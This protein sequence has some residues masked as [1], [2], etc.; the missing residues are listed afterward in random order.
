[1][2]LEAGAVSVK[3]TADVGG[4]KTGAKK[5]ESSLGQINRATAKTSKGLGVMQGALG[6]ML[7]ALG[8]VGLGVAAVAAVKSLFNVG[9]QMEKTRIAFQALFGSVQKGNKALTD[10]VEFANRTP[11]S[12]NNVVEATKLLKG[13]GIASDDISS[14]LT[15]VG[16]A[17]AITGNDLIALAN[18][19]GKSLSKPTVEQESL[20]QLN[21][22][23]VGIISALAKE[24]NTTTEG[25]YALQRAGK[26]TQ[27]RFKKAFKSMSD[28]G[29]VYFEGMQK[30]SKTFG[31]LFSTLLGKMQNSWAML[32]EGTVSSFTGILEGMIRVYDVL[33]QVMKDLWLVLSGVL[34]VSLAFGKAV[35]NAFIGFFSSFSR[36]FGLFQ[37]FNGE[38]QTMRIV[39]TAIGDAFKVLAVGVELLGTMFGMIGTVWGVAYRLIFDGVS[40]IIGIFINLLA[41][42]KPVADAFGWIAEKWKDFMS[43]L[44]SSDVGFLD[45]FRVSVAK[46][47]AEFTIVIETMVKK[48]REFALKAGYYGRIAMS[49]LAGGEEAR[50]QAKSQY[51]IAMSDLEMH[52]NER[53]EL[54]RAKSKEEIDIIKAKYKQE[55]E[56]AEKSRA[57]SL[58][59]TKGSK[60]SKKSSPQ[61]AGSGKM[62][63]IFSMIE[64]FNDMIQ[65]AIS[66]AA[67][68][69]QLEIDKLDTSMQLESNRIEA[70]YDARLEAQRKYQDESSQLVDDHNFEELAKRDEAFRLDMERNEEQYQA[71]LAIQQ[72]QGLTAQNLALVDNELQLE[73]EKKNA[74]DSQK[75]K[76]RADASIKKTEK[77][78]EQE[79]LANKKKF[80]LEK[81]AIE[82][83]MF[84]LNQGA[85]IADI[86]VS[87]ATG[88]ANLW[89][90]SIGSFG[91]IAGSIVA[92]VGTALLAGTSAAQVALVAS[93]RPPPV[94]SFAEGGLLKGVGTGTSDSLSANLSSGEFVIPKRETDLILDHIRTNTGKTITIENIEV[95]SRAEITEDAVEEIAETMA[96]RFEQIT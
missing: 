25:V 70:I 69:M 32:G 76:T 72:A 80:E 96:R 22:R 28:E 57:Q 55:K 7:P 18:V 1:M 49:Y 64:R 17:A 92:G 59:A 75:I 45:R 95:H 31:G 82:V 42:I 63:A 71:Q 14:T 78:K 86:V 29:G 39:L 11:F 79:L 81:H 36:A 73:R 15:S 10:A 38:G 62:G 19:V 88:I 37:M 43:S 5:A 30:Q 90:Q 50:A 51:D 9:A 26:L 56:E 67:D 16:D 83:K 84:K 46:F 85:K 91:L 93:Q 24:Y 44:K 34:D 2:A 77:Q 6:S 33:E 12:T 27:D 4:L 23:G 66:V 21:E 52:H 48:I 65:N 40:Y 60:G 87:T 53:I 47:R 20:N 68:F 58:P 8:A 41:K 61:G 35:W 13:Y 94:P 89:A 54:L 3:F 74:N